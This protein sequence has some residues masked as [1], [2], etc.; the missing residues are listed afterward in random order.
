[1]QHD[2]PRSVLDAFRV[3]MATCARAAD[4]REDVRRS[5]DVLGRWLTA[6]AGKRRRPGRSGDRHGVLTPQRPPAG[7]A[8]G[9]PPGEG[10][11]RTRPESGDRAGA[12]DAEPKRAAATL[13]VVVTRARWKATACR[14]SCDRHA[15]LA[16]GDDAEVE[17]LR[18]REESLRSRL[19]ALPDTSTWMLDAPFGK[20]ATEEGA[21]D[22]DAAAVADLARIADCY[23]TLAT[24]AE[25]A[26]ELDEAG[27][28]ADGPPASFLYLMAEAQSALLKALEGAPTRSDSD[29]R[30]VFLWLK[31]QTT[32]H[33]I[34]VDR[35]MRL[36]DPADPGVSRD[37]TERIR[38]AARDVMEDRKRRRVRRDALAKIRYHVK[39]L[40]EA[41]GGGVTEAEVSSLTAA[42][43]A[44]RE[45]GLEFTDRRLEETLAPLRGL[46]VDG[47]SAAGRAFFEALQRVP[48]RDGGGGKA[49]RESEREGAEATASAEEIAERVAERRV[50]LLLDVG[51]DV[52]VEEL[53]RGIGVLDMT[54][55]RI[56]PGSG[57]A[58]ARRVALDGVLDSGADLFLLGVRLPQDEYGHLKE[59]CL[60]MDALFVRL[61]G[62]LTPAAVLHQVSR[63]VGWRLRARSRERS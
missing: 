31:D 38:R 37:L 7:Q 56:D 36:D 30:D 59:R 43:D 28:F 25:V 39:K 22:A 14:L 19:R 5:M 23:E 52:D 54:V 53:A 55:A 3:L 1:M 48:P 2:I 6:E 24:A 20:R 32:R 15:A 4:E 11:A 8:A 26:M 35:H 51:S 49:Q 50:A 41:G 42:L 9:S 12:A 13:G 21:F 62:A 61:P 46:D 17:S 33:R 57:D 34:Y 40:S 45:A 10:A 44:W 29:E 16:A 27:A 60:D 18:T 47:K 58:A 63:Q